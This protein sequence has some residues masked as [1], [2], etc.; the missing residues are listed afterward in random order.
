LEPLWAVIV[1]GAIFV[2]LVIQLF[3]YGL[4]QW[5]RFLFDHP[6]PQYALPVG[7]VGPVLVALAMAWFAVALWRSAKRAKSRMWKVAVRLVAVLVA[8][9][10]VF[11]TVNSVNLVQTYL[12]SKSDTVM[13][14]LPKR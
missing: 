9:D 2:Y 8:V 7:Y 11:A 1:F 3:K 6:A 14:S 12:A 4:Y 5:W 10:V 13:D